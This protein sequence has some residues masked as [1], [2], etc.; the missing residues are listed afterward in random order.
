M[1]NKVL[2]LGII[3]S[4]LFGFNS[5]GQQDPQYTQYMYNMLS[6]N[7]AYAGSRETLSIVGL[8]RSQWV[9]LEGAPRTQ[10]LSFHTPVGLLERVGLGL[11]IVNDDLGPTH[12]TYFDANVSYTIQTSSEGYFSF[13]IRGGGHLLDINYSELNQF[14]PGDA[15]L[16]SDVINRFSPTVGA[17][18]YYRHSDTWYLGLSVPNFLTTKHLD[19]VALSE[20]NERMHYFVMGGYV[21]NVSDNVKFKPA[22]LSKVVTGSPL[23]LDLSANFLFNEKLTLGVAYRWSAAVSGL[24]GFQ[25]SDGLMLGFAYDKETTQLGRTKFDDGSYE[26]FLRFELQKLGRI[27]SP[28]FF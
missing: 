27:L 5:Y 16:G 11:S 9:G 4:A 26:V 10:A 7:P 6:V 24:V 1:K 15:L 13:G 3:I 2:L 8:H 17:G 28:R 22:F 18:I 12:E 21:F 20:A 25:I 19:D 14:N 23:Q